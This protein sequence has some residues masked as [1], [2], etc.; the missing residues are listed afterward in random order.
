LDENSKS[1]LDLTLIKT[2]I[3]ILDKEVN[4]SLEVCEQFTRM[5]TPVIVVGRET[6]REIW[7]KVMDEAGANLYLVKPVYKKEMVARIK[8]VLRRYRWNQFG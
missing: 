2:D 4:K 5:G 3:V 6:N 1:L 8:A 7:Q